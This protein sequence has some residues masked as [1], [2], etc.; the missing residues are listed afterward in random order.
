ME[1]DTDEIVSIV[2]R[3]WHKTL[4]I[5]YVESISLTLGLSDSLNGFN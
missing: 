5:S 1:M 3:T 4:V 2:I